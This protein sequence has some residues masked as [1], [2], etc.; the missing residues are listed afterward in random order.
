MCIW[1]C[2]KTDQSQKVKTTVTFKE[3]PWIKKKYVYFHPNF[4]GMPDKERVMA[5]LEH[6]AS[7]NFDDKVMDKVF[8]YNF[9]VNH[10]SLLNLTLLT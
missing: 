7:W 9:K 4:T 2:F 1:L 3:C 10:T 8:A 6:C 5:A